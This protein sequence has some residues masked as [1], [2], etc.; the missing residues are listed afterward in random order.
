MIIVIRFQ[1]LPQGIVQR[2]IQEEELNRPSID[3]DVNGGLLPHTKKFPS[4][5]WTE[6]SGQQTEV[7]LSQGTVVSSKFNPI[8]TN[9]KFLSH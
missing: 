6:P 1:G 2:T 9:S 8:N 4:Q 5:K 7:R 3:D